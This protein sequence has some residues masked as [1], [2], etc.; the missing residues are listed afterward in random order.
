MIEKSFMQ[1]I[2]PENKLLQRLVYDVLLTTK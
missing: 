1:L 2:I